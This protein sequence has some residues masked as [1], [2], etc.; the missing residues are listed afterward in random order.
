MWVCIHG[1]LCICVGL[2]CVCACISQYKC[3]YTSC[4]VCLSGFTV[5]E[6]AWLSEEHHFAC[7]QLNQPKQMQ[8][9]FSWAFKRKKIW[10]LHRVVSIDAAIFRFP[11]PL[12]PVKLV[13][14]VSFLSQN[15]SLH[16]FIIF[17]QGLRDRG[18]YTP[19]NI[20]ERRKGQ[21]LFLSSN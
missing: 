12:A 4:L 2:V 21:S 5:P 16:I 1:K 11:A 13:H 8:W 3:V 19:E 6:K 10:Y 15:L 7:A 18:V 9:S 20:C 17:N 14:C